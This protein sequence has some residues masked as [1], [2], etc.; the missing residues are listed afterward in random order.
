MTRFYIRGTNLHRNF[1]S[2][3]KDGSNILFSDFQ[4]CS[5]LHVEKSWN[6]IA[7]LGYTGKIAMYIG[8][9]PI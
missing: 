9:T 4:Q 3:S 6:I 1:P 5:P 7:I 2:L 8:Q